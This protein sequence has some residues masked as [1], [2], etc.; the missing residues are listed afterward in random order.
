VLHKKSFGS[1]ASLA[2]GGRLVTCGATTGYDP[3]IDLRFLFS[4]QLSIIIWHTYLVARTAE[5]AKRMRS[6]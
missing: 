5:A 4:R 6:A 1:I 2:V 3:K